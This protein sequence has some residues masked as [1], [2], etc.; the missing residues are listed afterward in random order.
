MVN[1]IPGVW[2]P[3]KMVYD[4]PSVLAILPG[5][6]QITFWDVVKNQ[7]I[8]EYAGERFANPNF[9][10]V[11]QDGRLFAIWVRS[12]SRDVLNVFSLNSSQPLFDLGRYPKAAPM[13]FSPDGRYL[14]VVNNNKVDVWDLQTRQKVVLESQSKVAGELVFS[15]DGARLVAATGEIW[16]VPA[17]LKAGGGQPSAAFDP[18]KAM[19][20]IA[21]SPNGQVIVG[22]EGSLW[23]GATGQPIDALKN[24]RGPALSQA[25]TPDGKQLIRQT[26]EGVIEVWGIP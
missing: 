4:S 2:Y 7:K 16:D 3:S 11:S 6:N 23:D 26:K 21:L 5:E 9:F 8:E 10:T 17:A 19:I 13:R 14:A 20:S 22:N 1:A 18:A 15:A 25:F 24:T 12:A